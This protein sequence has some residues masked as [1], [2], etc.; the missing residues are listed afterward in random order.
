[1]SDFLR[2]IADVKR[3]EV[4]ALKK[5]RNAFA[6]RSRPQRPFFSAVTAPLP[7]ALAI[8]AEIKKASPSKGALRPD[9][10]VAAIAR[11][12]EQAGAAALSVLTEGRYFKGSIDDLIAASAAVTLPVL[13]KDFII[14]PVQVV[15][16]ASLNA[17][18]MLLIVALLS[19]GQLNDLFYA[20]LEYGLD[21]LVEIHS[22]A[23][24]EAALKLPLTVIGVNSR[25]LSTLA[26]ESAIVPELA[27]RIPPHIAVIAESGIKSGGQARALQQA[28]VRALLVGEALIT[29]ADPAALI[30]ELRN[31]GAH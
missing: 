29:A 3:E 7:P 5:Q 18:A 9:L 30:G 24:L 28:G 23:E 14:D 8:I 25:N 27:G 6:G 19:E 4:Q 2:T 10:D 17:D 31:A 13:R 16:T 20:A 15:Q 26:V 21:P 12:Y 22:P 1:M 11:I